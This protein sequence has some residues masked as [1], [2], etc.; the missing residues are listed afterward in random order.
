MHH[1]EFVTET[2][3]MMT[4]ESRLLGAGEGLFSVVTKAQ[5]TVLY[6][7]RDQSH[8]FETFPLQDHGREN[9]RSDDSLAT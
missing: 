4:A 1:K 7:I 2:Q 9:S 3:D 5:R 8:V 6:F